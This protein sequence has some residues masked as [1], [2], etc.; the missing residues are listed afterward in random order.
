MDAE[1]GIE[2]QLEEENGSLSLGEEKTHARRKRRREKSSSPGKDGCAV[3]RRKRQGADE[4]WHTLLPQLLRSPDLVAAVSGILMESVNPLFPIMGD[5][6]V[7]RESDF[8]AGSS[9]HL[10]VR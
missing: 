6:L 10:D 7:E 3:K 2:E 9:R 8:D 1:Q 5:H 4:E